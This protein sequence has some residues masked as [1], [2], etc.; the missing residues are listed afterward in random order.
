MP[1][2]RVVEI[3]S[4]GR[5]DS[6]VA[7]GA[8]RMRGW[9][10]QDVDLTARTDALLTLDPSGAV[11][12]GCDLTDVARHHLLDGGALIFPDLPELPFD[13]YRTGLYSPDELYTGIAHE[14]YA[15]TPDARIYAWSR[16]RDPDATHRMA[17][18]LHDHAIDEALDE[19]LDTP[20]AV[21]VMGGHRAPRGGNDFA[22][23]AHLGRALA[24]AGLRVVT[25]G[26]PG[27]MEA[28]NLGAY[29]S[30]YD[31]DV[32]DQAL[33]MLAAVPGF[34]PSV[35]RWARAAFAVRERWPDGAGS[36]GIP[37]WFYGHEP[38][39]VFATGVAKYFQNSLR[40]G[41]L[42]RRCDAGIVFLPGAAG[43]VQEIFQDACENY[44]AAA[45]TVAPMVLVGHRH[46]TEELP[47]WPLLRALAREPP[48]A[49]HVH[50]VDSVDEA[51]NAIRA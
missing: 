21:G 44:Y 26:G 24:K 28:A 30:R 39:N 2:G 43:T 11:L 40:E 29:V 22:E 36:F 25:G 14:R 4:L 3:D 18:A 35:T 49:G 38:P 42:V 10:L 32:L 20:A 45:A 13:A 17:R 33:A 1:A 46:W 6:L 12:L 50:L 41:T 27:A 19:A 5:F 51:V 47:V 15:Q 8:T 7:A 16:Q 23:A 34:H 48:M 31:V 37:T 9:R